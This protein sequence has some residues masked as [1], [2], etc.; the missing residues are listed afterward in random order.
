MHQ[1]LTDTGKSGAAPID[2]ATLP[3]NALLRKRQ[4]L[5]IVPFSGMTLWRKVKDGSFPAPVQLSERIPAW[6]VADVRA[7]LASRE[8]AR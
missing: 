6:R 4:V 1:L 2:L 5:A 8:E 3:G 7:W